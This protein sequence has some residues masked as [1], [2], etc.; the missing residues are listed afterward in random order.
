MHLAGHAALNTVDGL[1]GRIRCDGRPESTFLFSSMSCPMVSS[2]INEI[3][4]Y[5]RIS[6]HKMLRSSWLRVSSLGE[7]IS[8]K[9]DA[10][11]ICFPLSGANK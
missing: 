5:N 9:V 11:V 10:V 8:S 6:Y 2:N 3:R 7:S 1:P 4:W